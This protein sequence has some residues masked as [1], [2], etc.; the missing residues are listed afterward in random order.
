M[1]FDYFSP[2][3]TNSMKRKSNLPGKERRKFKSFDSDSEYTI[4][5]IMLMK[6]FKIRYQFYNYQ[7]ELF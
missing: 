2:F 1:K 5:V 6:L 4:F 7:W 3:P